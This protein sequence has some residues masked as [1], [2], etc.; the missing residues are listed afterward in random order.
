MKKH[1]ILFIIAGFLAGSCKDFLKE[2]MVAT[3]TQDYFNSEEGLNQLIIGSYQAL[4]F[5]YCYT[6]GVYQFEMGTDLSVQ[7]S[8]SY[9]QYQHSTWI[10]TNG[11]VNAQNLMGQYSKGLLGAY[12]GINDCNLAIEA[13]RNG[14]VQGQYADD[15]EYAATKLSEVLF[16][17]AWW[18][19]LLTTQLGDVYVMQHSNSSKPTNNYFPRTSGKDVYSMM[20][21][22]LRYAF[23]HLPLTA[24]ERGRH[25]KYTAAHFLAKLYLERAQGS[26][27]ENSSSSHLK[28]LFKGNVSTDL[29]SCIY[30]ADF[31]INSGKFRLADDFGDLFAV[32]KGDWSNENNAEIIM[33][34]EFTQDGAQTEGNNSRFGSR[35]FAFF[36]NAYQKTDW[37]IPSY[38]WNYGYGTSPNFRP[39][40]FGFDIF[41][42]KMADSRFQKS[43]GLEYGAVRM[44]STGTD[45]VEIPFGLYESSNSANGTVVW[46]A[47]KAAY[48]NANILPSYDRPSWDGRTAKVGDFKTGTGDIGLCYVENTKA[49]AIKL[50]DAEAQPYSGLWV[51]WIYDEDLNA[52]YY[53][54]NPLQ[55]SKESG[56]GYKQPAWDKTLNGNFT[57]LEKPTSANEPQ[58]KKHVDPNRTALNQPY[59]TRSVIIF[60]LAETYLMRAEAYG[61]KNNFTA[62]IADINVVRSRAAYKSGEVR[63]E[64]LARLYP[65]AESLQTSERQYPYTVVADK[66]NDMLVDASYWDG[67]SA[68]S[69]AEMYPGENTTGMPGDLFRFVNFIHNEYAREMNSE[70]NYIEVIHHAGTQA[71]RIRWHQQLAAPSTYNHWEVADNVMTNGQGQTGKGKGFFESF[72]TFRPYPQSYLDVLTDENNVLL[73]DEAKAAY[74]NP[75][76]N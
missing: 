53:R 19:H 30:F 40:D 68:N 73:S 3:I 31:V 5:K 24:T 26:G 11:N 63:A 2:E 58:S 4:R 36:N 17:R 34:A 10:G 49:T 35:F 25:T 15:A 8:N 60:R 37:G 48:F 32:G 47:S 62:A 42:N 43:F 13:I 23:D 16:N 21:A 74:Q 70:M 52:Y 28:M 18:Y 54:P 64:V 50:K 59:S 9:D 33:M 22:D 75:G 67:V 39:T 46:T 14:T 66:T 57:G 72:H 7:G 45:A 20:I 69:A 55:V 65:G 61:R 51:R 44:S 1:I 27:F 38:T 6:E 56:G 76:Y 12:P 71:D 41:V 29:D